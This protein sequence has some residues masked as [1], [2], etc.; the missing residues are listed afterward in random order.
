MK[1]CPPF[2]LFVLAMGCDACGAKTT[3]TRAPGPASAVGLVVPAADGGTVR[4]AS[5]ITEDVAGRV[6]GPIPKNGKLKAATPLAVQ[7]KAPS[8]PVSPTIFGIAWADT[9]K[10]LGA[11]AHRWGGNTTSR[12]NPKLGNAWSTANDWFWENVEIDSWEKFVAKAAEKGGRAAI[13]IPIMGWVAKDT[14]GCAFPV[15]DFPNQ[16]KTDPHRPQCGNGKKPDGKTPLDPPPDPSRWQ[17]RFTPEDAA[18]WVTQIRAADQKRGKRVVYQYILD[19]EPALWDSTHRDV[20]PEPTTYDELLEKT[21]AFGTAV[22]KADPDALIAGP[23]EWGW[24]GYFFSGKDA[25]AGFKIKPDR[26]AHGDEPLL[27]WYL[28]KLAEHEKKTGVRVLDVLDVHIYPQGEGVQGPDGEGGDGGGKTD[29]ATNDLRF[30]TTRSL[31]DR[32]YK[33]ESWI[34]DAVYLVPRMKEL[35]AQ[36]YP[37]LGFQIGEYNFG[38]EDHAA[39]AVALAEALGRFAL[40]GVSHAFYWTYPKK[41]KP[42]YW[43]FRAYRNYD[44]AG[45]HFESQIVPSSSPSGTSLYASRDESG[46]KWV[47]VALHF[48][49]DRP[50]DATITLD[51]CAAPTALKSF[52]Y[53]GASTGFAKGDA[54]LQGN[55]ITAKLPPYSIAVFELAM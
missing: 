22:R 13:T 32:E 11:T 42:A 34:D 29:R 23:A 50:F 43:A 28:K 52:V 26:R 48:G 33:D 19:N 15:K 10:D 41:P 21:I 7:C 24:P 12:Y 49:A 35:I 38:A 36:N 55:A 30:R 39:G 54:K 53:A 17:T 2:L 44:D 9:D 4:I 40:Y 14:T 27:A 46:K 16:E 3:D 8:Q 25:K 5:A 6:A 20:H 18:A 47:L 31:W 37:G 45:G 51:G 1:R